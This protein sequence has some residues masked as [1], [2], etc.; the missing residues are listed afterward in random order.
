[1]DLEDV[2]TENSVCMTWSIDPSGT[3]R[4]RKTGT[5]VSTKEGITF[6]GHEYRLSPEDIELE[7]DSHLGAGACGVVM[8]GVIKQTGI[9]VAVAELQ[10]V[11]PQLAK[12]EQLINEIRGLVAADGCTL[13]QWGDRQAGSSSFM[14]KRTM[15]VH[16]ALEFMDLGSLADLK[17]LGFTA[18][19]SL[20]KRLGGYGVEPVYLSNITAQIMNGLDYLHKQLGQRKMRINWLKDI[21]NILH[22]RQGEVKLTDFGIAKAHPKMNW[23]HQ[24][25]AM[26]GTFVGTVTYMSPERCL[27][28]QDYSFASDIWS[29]GMVLFELAT[30]RYPF[31]E[32]S[33]FVVLFDHLCE[34]PEPRHGST[35]TDSSSR[36]RWLDPEYFPAELVEF[37]AYCLTRD[38]SRRPDAWRGPRINHL[39]L[40]A[41]Q[42]HPFVTT[43]VPTVEQLAEW[44]VS[45]SG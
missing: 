41:G 34:Q 18:E 38:V 35:Q 30:G 28:S 2:D 5:K 3:M 37:D 45:F 26:A 23:I 11:T 32:L 29:V 33:S 43:N 24:T 10:R 27:G 4:H 15:I 7:Q 9:P 14:S 22:N 39:N 6:E 13:A 8:K 25:L 20:A 44:L 17:T 1:M 19:G 42:V 40:T 16:V 21:R 36:V 12:R 31:E